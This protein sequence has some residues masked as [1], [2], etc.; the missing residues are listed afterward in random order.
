MSLFVPNSRITVGA[1]RTTIMVWAALFFGWWIL[2][3]SSV[4]PHPTG[5]TKALLD[6]WSNSSLIEDIISSLWL[7]LQAIALSTAL[8][9][10]IAYSAVIPA[11]T[12]IASVV[13]KL[14]FLGLTGLTFVF[15][16]YLQG[17]ALKV[18]LLVMGMSVF[19]T[20]SMVAVVQSIPREQLD[21]ARTLRMSEWRVMWEVVVL[22]TLDK[23]FE[24][25][26]QN[27]AIGWMMLT[28]VE[29]LVR[30]DGG[31]GALMLNE[32]KHF[33]LDSVFALQLIILFIGLFQDYLLGWV[34]KLVC[35]YADL[36][37]A[38]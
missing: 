24:I 20:T 8:S 12:P 6:L 19:F 18:G 29:G 28:M 21:H 38:K 37:I 26:R 32:N 15:G 30:S 17:H 5:I 33:K 13:T 2:L 25:L 35:P 10:V 36:R 7:N 9:L 1:A 22:G 3:A 31:I 16:L 11:F 14:R 23:A 27:A 4:I 34:R